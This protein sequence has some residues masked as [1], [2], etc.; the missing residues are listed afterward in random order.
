MSLDF[1]FSTWLFFFTIK[2]D[3]IDDNLAWTANFSWRI[4][5]DYSKQ[6][7]IFISNRRNFPINLKSTLEKLFKTFPISQHNHRYDNKT[8]LNNANTRKYLQ[9]LNT[10][11]TSILSINT[12]H[13]LQLDLTSFE[14]HQIQFISNAYEKSY[15][16]FSNFAIFINVC[17]F[18]FLPH[19]S[20]TLD[21]L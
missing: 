16:Y 15:F 4:L 13:N 7:V 11:Q 10:P 17:G 18:S 5:I 14:S 3:K 12:V 8:K 2:C 9:N 19:V 20:A 1:F 6:R 21:T